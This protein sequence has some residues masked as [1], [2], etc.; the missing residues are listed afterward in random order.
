MMATELE[1][2]TVVIGRTASKLDTTRAR[3]LTVATLEFPL[4]ST[5]RVALP[6]RNTKLPS[7]VAANDLL[8]LNQ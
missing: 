3:C 1:G 8:D 2:P 4:R 7:G 5:A 6:P